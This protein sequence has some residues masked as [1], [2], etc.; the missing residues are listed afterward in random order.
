MKRKASPTEIN[1][2]M[3]GFVLQQLE[4]RKGEWPEIS[5][6]AGVPYFTI[7]K[8]ASGVTPNPRIG[9]VQRLANFFFDNPK[10]A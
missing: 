8:I 7:S 6:T 1:R 5:K 3:N 4:L 10:A 2:D 9:T